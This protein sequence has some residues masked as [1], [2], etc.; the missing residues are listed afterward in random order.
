[1]KQIYSM[2]E[3]S[4]QEVTEHRNTYWSTLKLHFSK[5]L[6]TVTICLPPLNT[7]VG[8][9]ASWVTVRF[10]VGRSRSTDHDPASVSE[11]GFTLISPEDWRH[12]LWSCAYVIMK[13]GFHSSWGE[14][15]LDVNEYTVEVSLLLWA[16]CSDS[17]GSSPSSGGGAIRGDLILRKSS[18]I[19]WA[20]T[21]THT[22]REQQ[23]LTPR[24]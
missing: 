8:L 6:S 7:I 12:R 24:I 15:D 18:D 3:W 20:L 14:T 17:E 1:M 21:H 11:G 2:T 22:D 9:T 16:C 4:T 23:L 5:Y 19:S 13:S 10:S